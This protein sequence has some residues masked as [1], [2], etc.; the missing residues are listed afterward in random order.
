MGAFARPL[1]GP[2]GGVT[3]INGV[4]ASRT[5][6]HHT[7]LIYNEPLSGNHFL[8]LCM[9]RRPHEHIQRVGIR[10]WQP[11]QDPLPEELLQSNHLARAPPRRSD[12]VDGFIAPMI[13]FV[14]RTPGRTPT[15]RFANPER[16]SSS[17][18]SDCSTMWRRFAIVFHRI[19]PL[20]C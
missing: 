16:Q 7:R 10:S 5:A 6:P 17:P 13:P 19:A 20:P 15:R 1:D 8:P 9:N 4:S 2:F 18:E 3:W 14:K 12:P 11:S